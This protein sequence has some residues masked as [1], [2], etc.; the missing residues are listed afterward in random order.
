MEL[1]PMTLSFRKR[2]EESACRQ[3]QVLPA[4]EQIPQTVNPVSE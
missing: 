2:S 1:D 4:E 3:R